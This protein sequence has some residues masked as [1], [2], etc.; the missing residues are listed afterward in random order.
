MKKKGIALFLALLLVLTSCGLIGKKQEQDAVG[1]VNSS[2]DTKEEVKVVEKEEKKEKS[3][4][5][6]SEK[7]AKAKAEEEKAKAKAKEEEKAKEKAEKEKAEKE[8]E[9]LARKEEQEKEAEANKEEVISVKP[10]DKAP[11]PSK[12]IAEK[13]PDKSV[14]KQPEEIKPVVPEEKPKEETQPAPP[15]KEEKP[16]DPVS[17]GDGKLN[18]QSL[19]HNGKFVK[20]LDVGVTNYDISI[21]QGYIDEGNIISTVTK[22]NPHDNEITYFSGHTYNY[23]GVASLYVG[24]IVTVTDENGV[25]YDYEIIDFKKQPAGK[26][27]GDGPIIGGYPL[28]K[29]IG[30][31]IGVE[32]I[33]VQ[34]CDVDDVPMIYF[35][36]PV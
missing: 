29:I 23:N 18:P 13:Q 20:Y 17:P 32:S 26:V 2:T 7:D 1:K 3:D 11:E 31:G 15:V 35:G 21:T 8:K 6:K 33:A 34:Y 5:I 25:G 19:Y 4:S 28:V 9:E 12:E 10:A 30:K 24:S 36:L 27:I 22:F 16:I 14:E